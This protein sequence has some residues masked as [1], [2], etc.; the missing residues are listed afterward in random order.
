MEEQIIKYTIDIDSR[1]KLIDSSAF[2]ILPLNHEYIIK[3]LNPYE[4]KILFGRKQEKTLYENIPR[5]SRRKFIKRLYQNLFR[6]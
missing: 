4:I 1:D 5:I 3:S 2:Y 6:I